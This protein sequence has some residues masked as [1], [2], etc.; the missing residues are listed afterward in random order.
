MSKYEQDVQIS[1]AMKP[2]DEEGLDLARLA[3][4]HYL[5]DSCGTHFG[6]I[7]PKMG[8]LTIFK[9][10]F[11]TSNEEYAYKMIQFMIDEVSLGGIKYVEFNKEEKYVEIWLGNE[12]YALVLIDTLFVEL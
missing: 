2:L 10:R 9:T 12:H 11:T 7:A 8:Y 5:D 3:I 4:K 6:L 1:K